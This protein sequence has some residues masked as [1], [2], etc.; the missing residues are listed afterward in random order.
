[1]PDLADEQHDNGPA[2]DSAAYR[3]LKNWEKLRLVYNA[4]LI[5]WSSL[6]VLVL[7]RDGTDPLLWFSIITGGVIANVCFCLGP[8]LES[9]LVWVGANPRTARGWLFALGTA[10]TALVATL[11]IVGYRPT[12]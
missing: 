10:V 6:S 11:T 12:P 9:Y 2:D 1:M 4:V 8:V 3:V 5:P 7:R